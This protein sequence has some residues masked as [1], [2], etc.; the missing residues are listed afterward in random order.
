MSIGEDVPLSNRA[1]MTG[2][3]LM[4]AIC[5]FQARD[6]GG[7]ADGLDAMLAALVDYGADAT[8][9][10]EDG[11]GFGVR[12]AATEET[13]PEPRVW[14]ARDAGLAL[15]VDA[16]FDDRDTLCDALGVP[17][18]ERAA[19]RDGD[20]LLRAY[21]RWGRDCPHHLLG[22]YAFAVWDA[23]RRVL[24]CARDHI[25][26]RPFYYAV[27]PGGFLF[28]SA[29]EAVLAAPGVS[30]ALDETVV[31]TFLTDPHT[32]SRTR[33]FFEAVR[34]L[35]PGHTLTVAGGDVRTEQYWRPEDVPRARPAAD[36]ATAE[37]FLDLYARAVRDRL[38][39]AAD[40]V[41]TH[42]SG[43]LDSSSV[44]VLATRN[45]AAR[46]VRRRSRSVGRRGSAPRRPSR[47][48]RRN[49]PSS[50]RSA[51]GKG[52]ACSTGRRAP[53]TFLPFCGAMAPFPIPP[54]ISTKTSSG[55]APHS[56][57]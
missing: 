38:R 11:V 49:T 47:R 27:T 15:A 33:T 12:T 52:C 23:R 2:V 54:S 19:A 41:G 7:G 22:D 28:A 40:P 18:P 29:V 9:W 4:T 56:K 21:A 3:R 51:D 5:G 24:F 35:P 32:F 43:G 57:G 16:R 53:A 50:I 31:A 48:T 39:G 20:L 25:G 8:T 1:T 13:P 30:D 45:S 10:T 42:L 44:A 6:V 55:G 17:P 46:T 37:A 36:D 34:K 14:V 26:V